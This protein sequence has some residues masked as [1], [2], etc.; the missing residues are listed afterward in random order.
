MKIHLLSVMLLLFAAMCSCG[1]DGGETSNIIVTQSSVM[2]N[3]RDFG[4]K[5][6]GSDESAAIGSL[7]ASV[8]V[9][10]GVHLYFP[11]GTYR[12]TSPLA[13]TKNN[14]FMDGDGAGLTI[15]H[16]DSADGTALTVSGVSNVS[17]RN[18]TLICFNSAT[19]TRTGGSAIKVYNSGNYTL[20]NLAITDGYTGLDLE[21]AYSGVI[22]C[23]NITEYV[24]GGSF[25]GV[26]VREAISNFFDSVDVNCRNVGWRFGAAIDTM[27]L[28]KCS[29]QKT[30]S[31]L[32]ACGM[33]FENDSA[34]LA[35]PR[36]V[37]ADKCYMEVADVG[38]S[39]DVDSGYG[40]SFS[41]C[42]SAWGKN[43]FRI[44]SAADIQIRGGDFFGCYENGIV[45]E[46]ASNILVDGA[47][48]SECS[49]KGS[50]LFSGILLGAASTGV[51]VTGCRSG[52]SSLLDSANLQS[53]GIEILSGASNY[54]ITNNDFAGNVAGGILD[55][56]GSVSKVIEG[57]LQ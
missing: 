45:V 26:K 24:S 8:D 43:A 34:S 32:P 6:D 56:G 10:S 15:L 1:G 46:G 19:N 13:V 41:D 44:G 12:F 50:S 47:T 20:E 22:R 39:Y 21:K 52:E 16:F 11:S 3:V 25:D 28:D 53:C 2:V 36:W 40:I 33:R 30:A 4:V 29:V 55:G 42:Y 38:I 18:F 23:V 17:F 57:N 48:V 7:L 27:T 31:C 9:S 54:I 37:R 14:F 5:G 35:S 51:R 49:Q